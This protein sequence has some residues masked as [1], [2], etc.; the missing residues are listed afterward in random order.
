M[1]LKTLVHPR[2]HNTIGNA[3]NMPTNCTRSDLTTWCCFAVLLLGTRCKQEAAG[4]H[5]VGTG[6]AAHD[7]CRTHWHQLLGQGGVGATLAD[8][9]DSLVQGWHVPAW[10]QALVLLAAAACGIGTSAAQGA[11]G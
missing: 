2:Q 5:W 8:E 7:P 4:A 9:T 11:L 10:K 3:C 1:R 6:N